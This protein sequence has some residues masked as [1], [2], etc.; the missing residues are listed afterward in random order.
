MKIFIIL[1]L[2]FSCLNV[3]S[4]TITTE[5]I[6]VGEVDQ[7]YSPNNLE[8][9]EKVTYYQQEKI[10]KEFKYLDKPDDEYNIKSNEVIYGKY[11]NYQKERKFDK[12]LDE[13]RKIIY[14]Y[15]DLKKINY[16]TIK[17]INNLLI[18][19][20]ILKYKN[21]V[22]Y[23]EN[24]IKDTYKIKL[25]KKYSPEYLTLELTCFLKQ[26]DLKGNFKIEN[27][28]FIEETIEVKEKGF[29]KIKVKLINC[30]NK[31]IYDNKINKTI[32]I[33]DKFYIN[34][35]DKKI[36]YRYRK[37]Y[38]KYYKN[39]EITSE[40]LDSDYKIT[41]KINKYYLY[42][43]EIIEL[44]DD[45]NLNDYLD[46]NKIIKS[47]TIPISKL[48]FNYN[49]VC[50]KTNLAIKYKSFETNLTIVFNCNK[51]PKSIVEKGKTKSIGRKLFNILFTTIFLKK[52]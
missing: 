42:R 24:N 3:Y 1:L 11:S 13:E 32:S 39:E 6:K 36:L 26:E 7:N 33:D 40:K 4:Q 5:Y 12:T 45:I 8:K 30:L 52:M 38:Y 49:K 9:I 23:E 15:Q 20:I 48:N 27:S 31:M 22:I 21:R 28:K 19:K 46:L 43:K 14:Y 2:F 44:Y 35:V 51:I 41:N 16:L 25:R 18:T 17:N 10:N 47:S 50:G 37:K 29:T 34:I